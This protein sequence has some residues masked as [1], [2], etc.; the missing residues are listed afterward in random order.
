MAAVEHGLSRGICAHVDRSQAG[1]GLL[2]NA[3]ELQALKAI[4]GEDDTVTY[5]EEGPEVVCRPLGAS[6]SR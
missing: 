5:P 2:A 4:L 1:V 6:P 3:A